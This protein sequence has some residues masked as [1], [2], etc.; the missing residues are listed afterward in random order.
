MASSAFNFASWASNFASWASNFAS[1]ASNFASWA[2]NF[3]CKRQQFGHH[4][5][6][7]GL[8]AGY[9][10]SMVKIMQHR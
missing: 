2:S 6:A 1:W 3:T 10:T 4:F 7:L 9:A 8:M 5:R